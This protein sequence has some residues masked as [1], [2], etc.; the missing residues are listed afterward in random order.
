MQ[1]PTGGNLPTDDRWSVV[2]LDGRSSGRRF[3][4]G[5]R[6]GGG[7]KTFGRDNGHAHRRIE[8]NHLTTGS[9]YALCIDD[10]QLD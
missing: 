1:N 4:T 5:R 3:A 2:C 8:M 6:C 7:I 9:V 10:P